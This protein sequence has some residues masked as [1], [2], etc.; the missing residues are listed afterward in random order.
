MNVL[1]FLE[2]SSHHG[3]SFE[4]SDDAAFL[5]IVKCHIGQNIYLFIFIGL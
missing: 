1:L 4:A 2:I 5:Q 3:F